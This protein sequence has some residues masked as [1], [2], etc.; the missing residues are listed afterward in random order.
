MDEP[1]DNRKK[2]VLVVDDDANL[3]EVLVEKLS[4]SGIEAIG[5]EDGEIGLSKALE[6]HPEVILLDIL[7]PKLSGWQVLSKLR[8]DTWGKDVKVIMLTGIED[9]TAVANAMSKN[10]FA[11]LIKTENNL[12]QIVA[13]V[14]EAFN[15]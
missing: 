14:K 7:M 6:M 1:K 4:L 13:K 2:R 3:R 10:T 8:E 5:A 11:Y 12:D 9:L 15:S